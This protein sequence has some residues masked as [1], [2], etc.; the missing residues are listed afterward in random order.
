LARHDRLPPY[1]FSAIDA[2]KNAA[3][4]A[5]RPVVDLGV[6]DPDRPTP[7]L[8][9]DAL[10]TAVADP[11][12]HRYPA[13]R[14]GPVLRRAVAAFMDERYGV[15]VDPD[16]EVLVLIGS[17]EGLGHLP[18]SCIE[19][20]DNALVPDLG[21]PVYGQATILA[22]GRPR[23]FG[24]DPARGF[25]PDPAE[26]AGL[27]D[28]RTRLLFLNYP[29]N[30]TGAVATADDWRTWSDVA[31]DHGVVLVNDAAYLEVAPDDVPPVSM[32]SA[33]DHRAR[34]VIELHSFS[35]LFNM[36]GWRVAFAVGHRDVVGDLARVKESMDSGVFTPIQEVAARALGPGFAELRAAV[37]EP[38]ARRRGMIVPALEAAGFAVFP[39][40]ATFYVWARVPEGESAGEF[41]A[42]ALAERDLV[43]TPGTGF[44][45]GGEG[46][47]RISLTAPDADVATAAERLGGWR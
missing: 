19:E 27:A 35:K 15:P 31:H 12:G 39:S 36:T 16:T 24:L 30:P 45:P 22:G 46:W 37:M 43:L 3:R 17:K 6:G 5:G 25:R 4:A 40:R 7:R 8:L 34:R 42:R 38:Y 33:V 44:G 14:G 28:A 9:V 41:C 20:G 1:L 13:Q 18:L 29:N 11:A 2:A 10:A 26:L 23:L 21:Y 32:L 47:F